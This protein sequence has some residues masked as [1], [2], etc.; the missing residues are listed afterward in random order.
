MAWDVVFHP[1]MVTDFGTLR[2]EVQDELLAHAELLKRFGPTLGRPSVDTLK[3]GRVANLK[4]LRFSAG[5]GVWRLAFAFD[6]QRIAVLL[7]A[8]DKRGRDQVRF[9]KGLVKLAEERWATWTP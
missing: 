4:E 8:G 9:Y 3:G 2:A 7:V 1:E 5:G 6:A